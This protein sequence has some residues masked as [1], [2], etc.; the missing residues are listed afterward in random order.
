[1]NAFELAILDKLPPFPEMLL[2]RLLKTS[3]YAQIQVAECEDEDAQK[4][5]RKWDLPANFFGRTMDNNENEEERLSSNG[6][7]YDVKGA[8]LVELKQQTPRTKKHEPS[9]NGH[10]VAGLRACLA[11]LSQCRK[12]PFRPIDSNQSTRRVVQEAALRFEKQ[13]I[14][15]FPDCTNYI[16][17]IPSKCRP[18]PRGQQL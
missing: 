12:F 8:D 17:V 3:V 1:M 16:G 18:F 14:K 4:L 15:L 13:Q 11:V 6:Y 2:E 9:P 10:R 5:L 7:F